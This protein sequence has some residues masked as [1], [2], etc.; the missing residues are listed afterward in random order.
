MLMGRMNEKFLFFEKQSDFSKKI[1][2][3]TRQT[4]KVHIFWE[5]HRRLKTSSDVAGNYKRMQTLLWG[6]CQKLPFLKLFNCL[7]ET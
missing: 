6:G 4:F 7:P 2:T 3:Q 1:L 5:G